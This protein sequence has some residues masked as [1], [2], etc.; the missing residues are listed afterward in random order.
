VHWAEHAMMDEEFEDQDLEALLES[1]RLLQPLDPPQ[2]L[3]D[4]VRIGAR[5][6]H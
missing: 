6:V 2:P 1:D 3:D 4:L 5:E